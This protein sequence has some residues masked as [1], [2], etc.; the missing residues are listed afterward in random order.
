MIGLLLVLL[1][2][3]ALYW[4]IRLAVRHGMQ[5][6]WERRAHRSHAG[7]D[8]E[9]AVSTPGVLWTWYRLLGQFGWFG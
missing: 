8:E 1:S 4:V 3:L 5:D 2:P 6:A 9:Q 7:A